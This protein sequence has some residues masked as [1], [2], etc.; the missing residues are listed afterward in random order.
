MRIA[1]TVK[2]AAAASSDINQLLQI[3]NHHDNHN[4]EK[5]K[6]HIMI[7]AVNRPWTDGTEE[8]KGTRRGSRSE[9]PLQVSGVGTLQ[10][11]S[12]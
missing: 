12:V 11:G 8:E 5:D 7:S 6:R 4:K 10:E 3:D 2:V 1:V 9:A